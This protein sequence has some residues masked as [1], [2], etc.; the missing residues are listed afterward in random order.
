M[1]E[2]VNRAKP[3]GEELSSIFSG[4]I[5]EDTL[6]LTDGL[7]SYHVLELLTSCT[8][9]DVTREENPRWFNLNIVNSLC[10][11]IILWSSDKIY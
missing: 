8:V 9:V 2:T 5:V 10:S 7:R 4:H 6:A 1:D 3:S 11:F